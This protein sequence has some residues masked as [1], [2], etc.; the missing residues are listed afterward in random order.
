MSYE[1]WEIKSK[2]FPEIDKS[3]VLEP[4]ELDELVPKVRVAAMTF[5][6][7]CTMYCAICGGPIEDPDVDDPLITFHTPTFADN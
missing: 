3:I 7:E 2:L 5:I 1:S 4:R 6:N